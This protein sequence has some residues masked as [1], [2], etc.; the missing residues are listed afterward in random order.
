MRPLLRLLACFLALPVFDSS[1]ALRPQLFRASQWA[2]SNADSVKVWVFFR[3]KL[4]SGPEWALSPS[5]AERIR[6]TGNEAVVSETERAVSPNYLALIEKLGARVWQTSR[7][8]NAASVWISPRRLPAIENLPFVLGFRPVVKFARKPQPAEPGAFEA[9]P[10]VNQLLPAP[11]YSDSYGPTITQLDSLNIPIVHTLG[12]RGQGVIVGMLDDGFV[13]GQ[14]VFKPLFDSGRVLAKYDFIFKDTIV[15]FQPG[16]DSVGQGNHGTETWSVVGGTAPGSFLGGA[17]KSSFVLAKTEW[18]PTEHKVEEDNWVAGLEW[19]DSIGAGVISSSLGYFTFDPPDPSY[20]YS[21]LDGKT[22]VT[23][24]AA[25]AAANLG[26]LVC[27]AAGNDG[28]AD[29][30]LITPADAFDILACG[31][32]DSNGV[33]VFFSSRGPTADGRVKP[34]LT[35]QGYQTYLASPINLSGFTRGSGT[36]FATPL[37]ASATAVLRSVHPDWPPRQVREALLLTASNAA[38]PNILRGWGG[39][40][41]YKAALFRPDSTVTLEVVDEGNTAN[42]PVGTASFPIKVAVH[43]PRALS[44]TSPTLYYREISGSSFSPVALTPASGD[45]LTGTIPIASGDLE[46]VYYAAANGGV[47]KDPVFATAWLHRLILRPWLKDDAD[48]GPFAWE[49]TGTNATWGP[50]ARLAHSGNFSFS[51][52][53]R[54]NYRNNADE[55]WE[56][57][58]GIA[59][60]TT[61]TYFLRYFERYSISTGDSVWVEAS[62]NG[63]VSWVPLPGTRRTANVLS[64]WTERIVSLGAFAKAADFRIR[65]RL[66]SDAS[67]TADGWFVDDVSI[68]PRGD[69]NG[70]GRLTPADA[71]LGLNNIFLGTPVP[72]PSAAVDMDG[73]GTVS[74]ADAVCL[75][76]SIFLSSGCAAP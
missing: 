3:D 29:S 14:M 71:V 17:F 66:K 1:A 47:V 60:D 28:P 55:R 52:S 59:M 53:P 73:N 54:G 8:L 70:D 40:D 43:N 74:P 69:L 50:T 49:A 22:A 63:G 19:A 27:N 11:Q 20:T 37:I 68:L 31:A 41:V 58:R 12:Y 72:V 42:V 32:V 76:N 7:W 18:D 67:A 45:T 51:D 48:L 16:L 15:D 46:I 34:E 38:V 35:A 25:S 33:L 2:Q 62:T 61:T 65:F 26:I 56:M 39:P 13:T 44:V 10:Q 36:S 21:Q 23:S 64:T 6:R 57:V 75:L 24:I 30:T 5:A 4:G 9:F